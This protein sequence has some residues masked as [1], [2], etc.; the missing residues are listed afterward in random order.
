MSPE[1]E[2][3]I[4]SVG[5][6]VIAEYTSKSNT[7]TYRQLLDKHAARIAPLLP[8]KSEPWLWLN[9]YTQRVAKK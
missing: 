6:E 4:R 8:T 9:I 3:A 7:L 2:N 1:I 5:K